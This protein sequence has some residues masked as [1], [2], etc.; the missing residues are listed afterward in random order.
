MHKTDVSHQ[1][2]CVTSKSDTSNHQMW[3]QN[4]IFDASKIWCDISKIW[5]DGSNLIH[6]IKLPSKICC[7]KLSNIKSICCIKISVWYDTSNWCVGSNLIYQ[8][9]FCCD[10]SNQNLMWR[11][12]SKRRPINTYKGIPWYFACASFSISGGHRRNVR[13]VV[14]FLEGKVPLTRTLLLPLTHFWSPTDPPPKRSWPGLV[15]HPLGIPGFDL[16]SPETL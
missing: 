6:H 9:K 13:I 2:W 5:C 12:K 16:H 11:I 10:G 3:Y 4:Q 7:I 15:W 8:I 1:I 14:A